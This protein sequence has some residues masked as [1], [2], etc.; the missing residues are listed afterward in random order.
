MRRRR[1]GRRRRG[2]VA[3]A[4][5]ADVHV[6]PGKFPVVQSACMQV[7]VSRNDSCALLCM[8]LACINSNV[9]TGCVGG[10]V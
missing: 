7:R 10:V 3:G 2:A 5:M 4:A 9:H 8:Y 6:L 1:D